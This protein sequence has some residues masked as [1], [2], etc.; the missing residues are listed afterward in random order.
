MFHTCNRTRVY[1]QNICPC[2][3]LKIGDF[4]Q[5][6]GGM[7]LSSQMCSWTCNYAI[8]KVWSEL[9]CQRSCQAWKKR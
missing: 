4:K 3:S 7:I 5:Y 6:T 1:D 2:V 8:M 9:N